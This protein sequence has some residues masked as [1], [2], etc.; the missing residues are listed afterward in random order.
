MKPKNKEIKSYKQVFES[1]DGIEFD[2]ESECRI[3]ENSA[4]GVLLQRL[5]P[6]V[7][8]NNAEVIMDDCEENKYKTI[9]PKNEDDIDIMNQLCLAIGYNKLPVTDSDIGS[10]F[11]LGVRRYQ[12]KVDWLWFYNL[13]A[14]VKNVTNN[15]FEII[16]SR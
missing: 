6:C 11:L 14:F 3:Y 15:K 13:N 1:Y 9:I 8:N 2:D 12:E 4:I 5:E 10:V 7:I 16:E